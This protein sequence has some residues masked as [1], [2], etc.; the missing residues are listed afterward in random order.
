MLSSILVILMTSGNHD[1]L[2]NLVF[3]DRSELGFSIKFLS[4]L[5][6]FLVAFFSY[7]QPIRYY[8]HA[9]NLN[10]IVPHEHHNAYVANTDFTFDEHYIDD[11]NF[12]D[13]RRRTLGEEHKMDDSIERET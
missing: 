13:Y 5:V 4:I 11:K 10:N 2:A 6:C 1:K 8:S 3:G 7:V 12:Q 9:S